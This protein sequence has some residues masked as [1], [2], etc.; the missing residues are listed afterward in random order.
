MK[1]MEIHTSTELNIY[2]I[3]YKLSTNFYFLHP[4][5]YCTQYRQGRIVEV[6]N[7]C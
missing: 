1:K 5:F 3:I 2:F 7:N 6:L 4:L